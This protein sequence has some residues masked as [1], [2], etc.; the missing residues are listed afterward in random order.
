MLRLMLDSIDL[1][2]ARDPQMRA[3][4]FVL[5]IMVW[6]PACVTPVGVPARPHSSIFVA[7][8]VRNQPSFGLDGK[9]EGPVRVLSSGRPK[10]SPTG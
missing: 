7:L 4:C 3:T 5:A 9:L 8:W 6:E 1:E 10:D 2:S